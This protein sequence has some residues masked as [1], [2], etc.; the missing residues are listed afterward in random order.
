M[1]IPQ[2]TNTNPTV[3]GLWNWV[4]NA[5]NWAKV[6]Y[7]KAFLSKS[8]EDLKPIYERFSDYFQPVSWISNPLRMFKGMWLHGLYE[9]SSFF[10][11]CYHAMFGIV[12]MA[13]DSAFSK[14][15]KVMLGFSTIV[16][17]F[18]LI[19]CA[20]QFILGEQEIS[21]K[22]MV[23]NLVG[24]VGIII[25]IPLTLNLMTSMFASSGTDNGV[26]RNF[27]TSYLFSG[28]NN[29]ADDISF[30]PIKQN[31]VDITYLAQNKFQY[32]P[33]KY[34]D[35]AN[36]IRTKNDFLTTNFQD[37]VNTKV[38]SNLP[39]D[40]MNLWS[41]QLVKQ[42]VDSKGKTEFKV[43]SLDNGPWGL[44]KENYQRYI[45]HGFI[46][47]FEWLLMD[48][49]F[50]FMAVKVV[51]DVWQLITMQAVAPVIGA[52]DFGGGTKVKAFFQA[53]V[54]LYI[55]LIMNAMLV[56]VYSIAIGTINSYLPSNVSI[57]EVGVTTIIAQL[58][59]FLG[60]LQGSNIVDRLLGIKSGAGTTA[61]PVSLL[62]ALGGYAG[63][64]SA[65]LG[66]GA[67]SSLSGA[68]VKGAK[69]M[70]NLPGMIS[71]AKENLGEKVGNLSSA[72]T[73]ENLKGQ[74][75]KAANYGKNLKDSITNKDPFKKGMESAKNKSMGEP[76]KKN[77]FPSPNEFSGS[78]KG[79][80]LKGNLGKQDSNTDNKEKQTGSANTEMGK[81]E[82]PTNDTV[83]SLDNGE[84]GGEEDIAPTSNDEGKDVNSD[85]NSD[86]GRIDPDNSSESEEASVPPISND[87]GANSNEDLNSD[88]GPIEPGN[89][90]SEKSRG[91]IKIN[92]DNERQTKPVEGGNARGN[93]PK[94]TSNLTQQLDGNK[95]RSNQGNQGHSNQEARAPRTN[96]KHTNTNGNRVNSPKTS[97]DPKIDPQAYQQG[98]AR[99]MKKFQTR[100]K[101]RNAGAQLGS[102]FARSTL[103]QQESE[104]KDGDL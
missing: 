45:T 20:Y 90:H 82:S 77:N 42:A 84:T 94:S 102:E 93:T 62:G 1:F 70:P 58:G 25:F 98:Y 57:M 24:Y 37:V 31:V 46:M 40:Q 65:K 33:D 87:G 104:K 17:L 56:R 92:P 23:R 75:G 76:T 19:K 100:K 43:Q 103:R 72:L 4:S 27:D 30:Q 73:P 18:Y 5:T 14:I 95:G 10:E 49:V 85:L 71:G 78:D 21:I 2:L 66:L 13:G 34:K 6:N 7:D 91:P 80:D 63:F 68:A 67:A 88:E 51:V 55:G 26:D 41:N 35:G 50:L 99:A 52:M 38:Q 8:P 16:L 89:N 47:T 53:V 96:Y 3:I 79:T 74:F 11:S 15:N 12:G 9:I 32:L 60:I 39:A 83:N 36:A 54:N 48:A 29:N 61:L 81:Q 101:K 59:L 64:K 22:K 86:E 28:D 69:A 97:T 44:L